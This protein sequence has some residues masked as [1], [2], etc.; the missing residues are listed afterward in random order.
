LGDIFMI[1]ETISDPFVTGDNLQIHIDPKKA[2]LV[3][4]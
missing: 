2:M 3:Q 1:G 4:S